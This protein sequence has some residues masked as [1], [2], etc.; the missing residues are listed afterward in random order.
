[1]NEEIPVP[2]DIWRDSEEARS[3]LFIST[4]DGRRYDSTVSLTLGNVCVHR[5]VSRSSATADFCCCVFAG[6]SIADWR[7]VQ[8]LLWYTALGKH[9]NN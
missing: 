3:I 7:A 6:D 9:E 1:M 4:S 2:E 8:V 5:R